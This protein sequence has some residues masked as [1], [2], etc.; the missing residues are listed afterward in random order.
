MD[1]ERAHEIAGKVMRWLGFCLAIGITAFC[2][3]M[4]SEQ[5]EGA[6]LLLI[7]DAVCGWLLLMSVLF[8][9][10]LGSLNDLSEDTRT[11]VIKQAR[12]DA[13]VGML[14]CLVCAAATIAASEA[15]RIPLIQWAIAPFFFVGMGFFSAQYHMAKKK[16]QLGA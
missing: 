1:L 7:A 9:N 16:L 8:R 6:M 10:R 5:E 14:L 2:I 13:F 4:A 15:T 12:R 11:H 3:S